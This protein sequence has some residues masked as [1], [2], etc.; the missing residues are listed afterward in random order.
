MSLFLPSSRLR[1]VLK[2]AGGKSGILAQLISHFPTEFERFVEPF[3]GGGAVV[4]S[5]DPKVPAT[6]NDANAEIIELYE[7]IRSH[8]QELMSSLDALVKGYSESF[9]YALRSQQP[10]G[11]VERAAR[12]VF[13]NK[14]G[15]NGLYRQNSKGQFN[16]PWGK[17]TACPRLYDAANVLAVSARM[18]NVVLSHADFETVIDSCGKGDFVYC[19]PPYE[20]VSRSASFN[21]YRA[22]G[23]SQEEQKRLKSACIRAASR[24]AKIAISNSFAAF[25]RELYAD[26]RI[27][28]VSARRAINSNG[29]GRGVV[30]EVLVQL[31]FQTSHDSLVENII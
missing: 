7:V 27:Q 5:L 14:T 3:V 4:L 18:Q 8:P 23:F 1:P 11:R 13:L 20:P 15:F 26:A 6:I 24:G 31:G 30:A 28:Q 10:A 16:V 21:A 9:F 2:W 19:D 12:T 22:G 17:R 25:I 29:Q